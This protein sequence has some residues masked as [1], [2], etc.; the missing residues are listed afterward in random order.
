MRQG[1]GSEATMRGGD[2]RSRLVSMVLIAVF[3]IIAARAGSLAMSG[4]AP[5]MQTAAMAASEEPVR[6]ADIT[7]RQG[8]LLATSV[9]V[10]SVYADPRAIGDGAI[11]AEA[12]SGIF[13]DINTERLTAR[14]NDPSRAFVWVKRGVTPRQRQA[15][16]ELGLEGIGFR[17]EYRRAYP[18]G[19]LAGHVVGYAG[20][21]GQGL[22]GLEFALDERLAAGGEAVAVTIDANVQFHVE[23]ELAAGVAE[24]G[25][26]AGAA[27]VLGARS[28]DVL[29]MAS[30]PP[31]DPHRATQ[32]ASD[33]PARLNRASDAVYELGSV[34]K[35]LT[36]AGA[37]D[38][39]AIRPSDR[40]DVREPIKIA[41]RT[42]RD[43]HPLNGRATALEILAE[44][45]NIGTVK[46]AWQL[47]ARRQEELLRALGL[48]ERA[49]IEL[50]GSARPILPEAF[51]DLSLAT[52]SY[53]HG[54]A[55]S[56]L[57]FAGAF[58]ALANGGERIQPTLLL[59]GS[60]EPI[61]HRVMSAPTAALVTAMMLR[62]VTEGT[63]SRADVP[64]YRVAGKTGTAEKP[65][66]GGYSDD[67]NMC[68]FAAIFPADSPEYVVLV[69]LD[70]P[71]AGTDRGR[72]AAWNAAP[73]AGRV[74][75][76]IAPIL[77]VEPVFD[78]P[79]PGDP[80]VRSVSAKRRNAL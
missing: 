16:F 28:G 43:D 72:T 74:I 63:G 21:D 33:D 7:D 25:A 42:I 44:S 35:P 12:L 1:A 64:G 37:L 34:F 14:L 30:W 11:V 65:I 70:S 49:Q 32:I 67:E 68:S 20:A 58:S 57:A 73:T 54:L 29:A 46:V 50:A 17:E 78:A 23:A 15:V 59:G 80:Q 38:A 75:D 60:D 45:S 69:V 47:G 48:F 77:G 10:Y 79:Q 41:G 18:K 61:S 8:A 31:L 66:P 19:T 4:A 53:G 39:G 55:V 76:R 3:A 51:D 5:V 13:P 6:R 2:M 27:I 40:F 24:Y 71:E 52:A 56:P 9:L 26:E 36:I 22:G 62:A